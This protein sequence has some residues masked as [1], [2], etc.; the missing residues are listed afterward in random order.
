MSTISDAAKIAKEAKGIIDAIS[1][2]KEAK[3]K[4]FERDSQELED[5]RQTVSKIKSFLEDLPERADSTATEKLLTASIDIINAELRDP[6]IFHD[7]LKV[8]TLIGRRG[9]LKFQRGTLKLNSVF[10][11]R[12]LMPQDEID[13]IV[14][15]VKTAQEIVEQRTTLA[16]YVRIGFMVADL[17]VKVAVAVGKAAA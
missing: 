12:A 13:S 3:K 10:D 7:D 4:R 11:T 16:D 8:A 17:V 2:A 9:E 14:N 5:L 6:D 15:R 1:E